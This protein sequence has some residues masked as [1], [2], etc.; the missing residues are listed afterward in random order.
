MD[1]CHKVFCRFTL[2]FLSETAFL[3]DTIVALSA[4][5]DIHAS[6]WY[7]NLQSH[8]ACK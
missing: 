3:F 4:G 1:L 6:L 8:V 5:A 2:L 7:V